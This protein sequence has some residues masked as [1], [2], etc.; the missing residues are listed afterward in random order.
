[1]QFAAQCSPR[2]CKFL[3]FHAPNATLPN[4]IGFLTI[5]HH[6]I[7]LPL[8]GI[9]VNIYTFNI[10]INCY[11]CVNGVYFGF[12][13]L[14]TLFKRGYTPDVTTFNTLLNGLILQDKTPE[15]VQLFKKLMRMREIE[16]NVVMYGTIVN[17]LCRTGEHY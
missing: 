10:V 11:C 12:S 8:I 1:M 16:P 9:S 7:A 17:R 6:A 2:C 4:I 5:G 15:A 13:L 3:Q 14:G